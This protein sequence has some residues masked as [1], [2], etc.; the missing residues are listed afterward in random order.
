M[1]K[2]IQTREGAEQV[3]AMIAEW[4][5][6]EFG[7][8][9]EILAQKRTQKQNSAMHVYFELLAKALNDA[10]LEISMEYL[11]KACDVPWTKSSVKERLWLPIM[12]TLTD[13]AHTADLDRIQVSQVYEVLTRFMTEKHGVFVPF[14]EARR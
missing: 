4:E 7:I 5:L 9:V 6:G 8:C 13:H 2:Y 10:G 14:P 1:K 3:A 11:G 12:E